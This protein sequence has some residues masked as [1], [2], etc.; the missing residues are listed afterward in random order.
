MVK[1]QY[2]HVV[3][4]HPNLFDYAWRLDWIILQRIYLQPIRLAQVYTCTSQYLARFNQVT[5]S[6][7]DI[8]VHVVDQSVPYS[9][10]PCQIRRAVSD[11]Q[12]AGKEKHAVEKGLLHLVTR[13]NFTFSSFV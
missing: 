5:Y 1:E 7:L 6:D 11:Q 8:F 2:Y 13:L 3:T 10:Y 12:T 9:P 4:M